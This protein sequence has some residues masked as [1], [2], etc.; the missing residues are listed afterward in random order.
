M[1]R[2]HAIVHAFRAFATAIFAATVAS[3]ALASPYQ[4]TA[5]LYTEALG[6]APDAAG[7]SAHLA[8]IARHGC[9]RESL[10]AMARAVYLGPEYDA[11][12][13]AHAEQALTVLRGLLSREPSAQELADATRLLDTRSM[14]ALLAAITAPGRE[15]AA[16][17]PRICAPG[18]YGW[19]AAPVVALPVDGDAETVPQLVARLA[20]ARPGQT[21]TL[22][23]HTVYRIDAPLVVKPGV[24]L[25]TAG[26]PTHTRYARQARIVR[27]SL[28]HADA[29]STIAQ[30]LVVLEP[31]AALRSVWISGERQRLGFA[32]ESINLLLLGGAGSVVRDVRTENS[33]GFSSLQSAGSGERV[34]PCAGQSIT[35]VLSTGYTNTHY[36]PA[37]HTD[38]FTIACEQVR[39]TG[40]QIVDASDVGIVVFAATPAVQASLVQNN[41]VVAAGLPAFAALG[42]ENRFQP[43]PS[44]VGLRFD[45]NTFFAAPDSHFD[46]GIAVGA[47]AWGNL[48]DDGHGASATNNTTGGVP[49]PMSWAIVVDGM[50]D[51]VVQGNRLTRV[52]PHTTHVLPGRCPPEGD[53]VVDL[54]RERD[55]A[56][57]DVQRP[58]VS[59]V[60]EGCIVF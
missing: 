46:I 4:F 54:A 17:V 27:G 3:T 9:D 33:A 15:F 59:A 1:P 45:A 7:W 26:L 49:T 28:F 29:H 56:H 8:E 24:T 38:G 40:N 43:D 16:A 10:A 47:N 53:V 18:S 14:D 34:A 13:Y 52:A 50:H 25:E 19:G 55:A 51:A 12:G 2:R 48:R 58:Y 36:G 37:D 57:V 11:L 42:I 30:A 21:V 5:K 60:L 6:R 41:V 31:G 32:N 35:D 44:F 22:A 20:D 23:P 39:V